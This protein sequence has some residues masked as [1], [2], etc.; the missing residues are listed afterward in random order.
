ML[1]A[2][3]GEQQFRFEEAPPSPVSL[4]TR[5]FSAGGLS[6]RT[7]GEWE[8]SSKLEDV[9]VDEAESTLKEALSLNYEE[10]RALLG[11]LEYQK[12]NFDGALQ[13]FRGIDI[14]GL[15][16]KMIMAIVGRT[17]QR[18]PRYNKGE[19]PPPSTSGMS[20]NSVTLLLEATLLKAKSLEEM[21]LFR[22]AA[23][24]CRVI[25]DIVESSLPN[26]MLEGVPRHFKLEEMLHKALELLPVLWT[27][28]GQ[29]DEA[30][31]AYRRALIKPWNL[32]PWRL[33]K[34]QKN[35]ASMLLYGAFETKLPLHLQLFGPDT[36][37][38]N[39]EEAILLLLLLMS[40]VACGEIKWDEEIMDHLTYALTITDQF[41]LLAEHVEQILPGVYNRAERW[42]VLALCYHAAGQNE[43]ALNLLKKVSGFS[44]SNHKPNVSSYLLGAKLCSLNQMHCRV[45]I[46]FAEKAIDL[47]EHFKPQVHKLLGI[48]LGDAAR[49]S[50][51]YLERNQLQKEALSSLNHAALT[52]KEDSE[53]LYALGVENSLQR[54]QDAA[55][56]NAMMYAEAVSGNSVKGCK[57]LAHVISADQRFKDAEM[58]VEFGLD[59]AGRMDQ[60]ELLRVKAVLRVA[61]EQPKEAIETYRLLL[62]LIQG[63]RD[64]QAK[65]ADNQ[66]QI[67]ATGNAERNL[68]LAA[69]QDLAAIYIKLG[70]C[71]DAKICIDRSMLMEFFS[72]RGWHTTGTL[73]EAQELFREAL[74]SFSMSLSIEPD[75]VPSVVS[76]AGV[77]MKLGGESIPIARSFLMN[78]L[79]LDPTNHEAW[80]DLGLISKQQGSLQQAADCFQAAYELKLSA[81]LESFTPCR[82]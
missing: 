41:E 54:N 47:S 17:Q 52:W 62:S 15:K 12:G 69:W 19:T 3:S 73:F 14:K 2:C 16:P 81:P 55:F 23:K 27:R 43:I 32:E 30:I 63:Q 5:D 11:R 64:L 18:K 6:S 49:S 35:L 61:Q 20:M 13:V 72:P 29:L 8:S 80:M 33:A 78:A 28:A 21:G 10:A 66:V 70:L 22:E 45:G 59:E 82:P 31:A 60:L 65:S 34:V 9:Q 42:Y 76:T 58:V 56:Q 53:V 37:K 48:C 57:L 68:E 51:C 4:A 50:V 25:L 74:V 40:K 46:T 26:G 24:E 79:R 39:T 38:S 77:L 1:C 7:A 67:F 71:S 75:Y 36:P 44:E